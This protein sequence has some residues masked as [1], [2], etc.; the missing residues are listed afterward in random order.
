MDATY[1]DNQDEIDQIDQLQEFEYLDGFIEDKT[2]LKLEEE[3]PIAGLIRGVEI[4]LARFL[5]NRKYRDKLRE[6]ITAITK[7]NVIWTT[8]LAELN[9]MNAAA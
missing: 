6:S 5:D 9:R 2:L 8:E 4:S 1:Y 3:I 7:S